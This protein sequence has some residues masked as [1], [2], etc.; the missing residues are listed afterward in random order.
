MSWLG[1]LGKYHVFE[2]KNWI[3]ELKDHPW[4][5]VVGSMDEA[6]TK[7]W[8]KLLNRDDKPL[9]DKFGGATN[10]NL[11]G[12]QASGVNI[13][14]A[15]QARSLARLLTAAF[16]G[17]GAMNS[18]GFGG[19]A[20]SA[21]AGGLEAGGSPSAA[22]AFRGL[23]Y[24]GDYG[25]AASPG[26]TGYGA[27]GYGIPSSVNLSNAGGTMSTTPSMPNQYQRLQQQQQRYSQPDQV[28]NIYDPRADQRPTALQLAMNAQQMPVHSFVDQKKKPPNPYAVGMMG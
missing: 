24:A 14:P 17:G 7:V 23:E 12:A 5:A 18:M 22:E 13:G 9:V 3:H 8:N 4:R 15:K 11:S 1:D 21:S 2:A 6:G 26:Y 19:G 25:G 27:G 28:D 16:G 10:D 20:G